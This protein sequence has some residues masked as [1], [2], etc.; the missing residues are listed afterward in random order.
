SAGVWSGRFSMSAPSPR[1]CTRWRSRAVAGEARAW[2]RGSTS[3]GES[4]PTGRLRRR[5]RSSNSVSTASL[6]RDHVVALE[7]IERADWWDAF[8]AATPELAEE[9]GM[10]VERVGSVDVLIMT[11]ADILMLNRAAGLGVETP[12]AEGQLD[13]VIARFHAAR[14][15]RFFID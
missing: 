8:R 12:A 9:L 13:E 4:P 14:V 7:R 10:R 2:P 3:S 15:P 1:A 11:A 6:T 5:S